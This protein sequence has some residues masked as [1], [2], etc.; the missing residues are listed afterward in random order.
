ME[1]FTP[2]PDADVLPEMTGVTASVQAGVVTARFLDGRF[3]G[4]A[5][6]ELFEL[7]MALSESRPKLLVD[8]TGVDFVPSGGMGILVTIHKRFLSAGGQL[9]TV[10][11][12][13]RVR[14]SFDVALMGRLLKLFDSC[15]A[16]REAFQ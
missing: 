5:V 15:A 11:A 2:P 7:A 8:T 9:H 3:D 10:I 13:P 16:A 12:D 14:E 4:N 1:P 6:R